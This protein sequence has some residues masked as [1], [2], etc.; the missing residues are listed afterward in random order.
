MPDQAA[1]TA[2][3]RRDSRQSPRVDA[4]AGGPVVYPS[5]IRED[6]VRLC[7]T[8]VPTWQ[9]F[10][11][12]DEMLTDRMVRDDLPE[13][14]TEIERSGVDVL[15]VSIGAWGDRMFS[16]DAAL[17][18]LAQW[19]RRFREVHRLQRIEGPDDLH[20]AVREGRTGILL[21]FQNS[22]QFEGDLGN[23]AR[24]AQRGI[25]MVQLT[26]NG[27]NAAGS[28]C[29]EQ[30]D[31]GLTAFGRDLVRELNDAGVIIDVSHCGARTSMETIEVSSTPV[32]V[33]HAGCGALCGHDRNKSDD[34][35]RLLG[36]RGGFFGVCAVPFFL[37]D[38]GQ[39]D[40]DDILGHIIHALEVA[41]PNAVGI[42]SDW[43]VPD[44][45]PQLLERLQGS[46]AR[47]GFRP[48]HHFEFT[49]RTS[50][51][52]SWGDGWARLASD[53][54]RQFGHTIARDILG[55]NFAAFYERAL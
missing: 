23:V 21:G 2:G 1:A 13:Y 53:V 44:T 42:G 4:L 25:R 43:G 38:D 18:D 8:D 3:D 46:A 11:A 52:E 50:G 33:S 5:G 24:L 32:A 40:V 16:L 17:F 19:D 15:S 14:W 31:D 28:G 36:E 20:T 45:P 37:C 39:A 7:E 34:L 48:E 41:G 26:Y 9:V 30:H 10:R 51:F 55:A 27:R 35:L 47:Q 29:T 49:A 54:R 22:D 6:V 12:F